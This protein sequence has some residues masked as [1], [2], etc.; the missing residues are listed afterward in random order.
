MSKPLLNGA[1]IDASQQQVDGITM[2]QHMAAK[3]P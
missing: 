2:P 3:H 1:D